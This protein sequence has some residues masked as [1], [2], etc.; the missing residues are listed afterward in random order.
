[1]IHHLIHCHSLMGIPFFECDSI[2]E[3]AYQTLKNYIKGSQLKTKKWRIER[4]N[5]NN[6][7]IVKKDISSPRISLYFLSLG[8]A[9]PSLW[10]FSPIPTEI[11]WSR[12]S[13]TL[14]G[15]V[16]RSLGVESS[17]MSTFCCERRTKMSTKTSVVLKSVLGVDKRKNNTC[18]SITFV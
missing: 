5:C 14:T 13:K 12:I 8:D 4:T 1:M 17:M 16:G 15:A 11:L 18:F 2:H 10:L 3:F 7:I 9:S 6:S